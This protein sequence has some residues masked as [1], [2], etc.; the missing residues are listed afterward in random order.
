MNLQSK[1]QSHG[2]TVKQMEELRYKQSNSEELKTIKPN[3]VDFLKDE[4]FKKDYGDKMIRSIESRLFHVIHEQ[5]LFDQGTGVRLSVPQISKFNPRM[6]GEI[7]QSGILASQTVYI[8]HDPTQNA[9]HI[10][11]PE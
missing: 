6:W 4:L 11:F 10:D 8:L 3:M 5:R 7:K 1:H 2:L 9:K